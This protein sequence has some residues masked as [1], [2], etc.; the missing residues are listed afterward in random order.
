MSNLAAVYEDQG[1]FEDAESLGLRVWEARKNVLGDNH[2]STFKARAFLASLYVMMEDWIRAEEFG[3]E[4]AQA[5]RKTL[6]I[7]HP[8]T[9]T[10]ISNLAMFYYGHKKW[11]EVEELLVQIAEIDKTNSKQPSNYLYIFDWMGLADVCQEQYRRD[12]AERVGLQ[13]V[14]ENQIHS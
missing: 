2:P 5:A 10:I 6:G 3:R 1:R 12:E 14:E 4:R 7:F 11:K 13:L 9:K 8:V